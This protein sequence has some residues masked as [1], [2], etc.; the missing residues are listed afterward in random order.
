MILEFLKHSGLQENV[1]NVRLLFKDYL[2]KIH[3]QKSLDDF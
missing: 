2:K 3:L 1:M